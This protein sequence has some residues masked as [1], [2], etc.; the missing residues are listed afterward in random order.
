MV[1]RCLCCA[2]LRVQELQSPINESMVVGIDQN[3][4][5][6]QLPQEAFER[7]GQS[8]VLFDACDRKS[9]QGIH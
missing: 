1:L 4:T 2:G 5:T 3:G 7:V 8:G 9:L 6:I